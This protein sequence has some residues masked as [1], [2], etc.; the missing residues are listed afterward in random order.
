[1][2][3]MISICW[4]V[5]WG[6]SSIIFRTASI[7][8]S[9]RNVEGRPERGACWRVNLLRWNWRNQLKTVWSEGTCSPHAC[10][11]RSWQSLYVKPIFQPHK[12]IVR[13][14]WSENWKLMLKI[15]WWWH[16]KKLKNATMG[17]RWRS[18]ISRTI[19]NIFRSN[20]GIDVLKL[21]FLEELYE[22]NFVVPY[23]YTNVLFLLILK[24]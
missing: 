16:E 8:Y 19:L 21:A 4:Y 3:N 23:V 2:S 9:V 6:S 20:N 10:I 24:N 1:M 18:E 11:K 7:V 5:E 22:K 12:M 14:W 15:M 17:N 13:N